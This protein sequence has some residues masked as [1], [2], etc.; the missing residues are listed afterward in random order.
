LIPE[1][2][3]R[4]TPATKAVVLVALLLS[5][6]ARARSNPAQE[7]A[8]STQPASA[9]QPFNPPASAADTSPT[10]VSTAEKTMPRMMIEMTPG[11]VHLAER[12][13]PERG[14]FSRWL[15]LQNVSLSTRY[16]F[17]ENSADAVTSNQGQYQ[18]A[19]KGAFQ[20]DSAGKFTVQSG[21]FSGNRFSGGWNGT[22]WGNTPLRTNT[23]LK[24]L[25]FSAKPFQGLDFQ[26]GSLYFNQGVNTEI[27]GYDYDGYL[28]GERVRLNRPKNVFFDELSVTYGFVGDFDRPSVGKRLHRLEQSNYHQFLVAKKISEQVFLSADYTSEAGIH[29]LRQAVRMQAHKLRVLDVLHFENYQ[30]V[31]LDVGYGFAAY[32]EKKL[33]SRVS[34]GGGYAQHDRA[35]LYSDR[36]A[37][38]KRIF[39][40]LQLELTSEFSISTAWTEAIHNDLAS[41]PR[42]RFDVAL[43]YDLLH[44]LRRARL[45]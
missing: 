31:G 22:G 15:H 36:F 38:G 10:Q 30:V 7:T 28:V 25:Y 24:Q 37:A 3:S 40:N 6:P 18:I 4:W 44:S 5:V 27:T 21:L 9:P 32:G 8:T 17:V 12:P 34:V 41:S 19:V 23:Y 43:N 2:A 11:D 45:F 14:K 42:T 13:H 29:T 16:N 1:D 39:V 20:F 26:Y 35:A 33:H